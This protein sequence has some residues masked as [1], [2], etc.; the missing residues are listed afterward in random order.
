MTGSSHSFVFFLIQRPPPTP[1]LFPY[2]TLFRSEPQLHAQG[3]HRL[4]LVGEAID[5]LE[6][7][8]PARPAVPRERLARQLEQGARV[9]EAGPS[10]RSG[11]G[12]GSRRQLSPPRPAT[13]RNAARRPSPPSWPTAL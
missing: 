8:P 3:C 1:T 7:E 11:R 12:G 5:D 13:V 9:G 4:Q 10:G 2:T 6:I